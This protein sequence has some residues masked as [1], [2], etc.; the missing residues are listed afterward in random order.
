MDAR[1]DRAIGPDV[2]RP[3]TEFHAAD[4]ARPRKLLRQSTL[5]L[6]GRMLSKLG[7]FATQILIV[8]YLSQNEYGGFAY[9]L[10][11]ATTLQNVIG[12]GLDQSVVRFLPIYQERRDWS[13][14]FGTI[15]LALVVIVAFG[16]VAAGGLLAL[17]GIAVRWVPNPET[18]LPLLL[19]LVLLAPLQALDDLLVALFASFAK[20]R[21]IFL[22]RFLLAPVLR[23][24]V[25]AAM[26]LGRGSALLLAWG[27]VASS[28]LGLLLYGYLLI[29]VMTR[30]GLLE[31][32]SFRGLRLP[33]REVLGFTVPLLTTDL[34]YAAMTTLSVL[35]LGQ[36]RGTA[37]VA[38]LTAVQPA[39]RMNEL[40]MNTFGIL[41][42]PLASRMFAR[43][44]RLGINTLYWRTAIWIAILTFPVFVATFSL[45]QPLTILL[46][47]QR[48]ASS[49]PVLA[50]LAVGSYFNAALGHNG[51]T[52]KVFGKVRTIVLINLATM[53]ASVVLSVLLIPSMG[54]LGA[55]IAISSALLIHNALKQV[56]LKLETGVRLF[57]PIYVRVYA[58]I[59]L[60]AAGLQSISTLLSPPIAVMAGLAVVATWL[61]VRVNARVLEVGE[62]FPEVRRWPGLSFILPP[63]REAPG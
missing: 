11:V 37:G 12:L 46:F 33:F 63:E 13:R 49:A 58:G 20:A 24:A 50:L 40:V 61:L 16:V 35:I 7:N 15:A 55:A 39:A 21:S 31:H 52:L 51:L 32:W 6:L 25:A 28:L 41:F 26:V 54:P 3:E 8:R 60:V 18:T 17:Q 47:G 42:V 1:S 22:R 57:D 27:Y 5:L 29:R 10:T 62:T 9:A 36:V 44:D 38:S 59:A 53:V 14:F 4:P 48:Y 56:G 34:T 43:H 19:V 23:L 30:E 2:S 45:A